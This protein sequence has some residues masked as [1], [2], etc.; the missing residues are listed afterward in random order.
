R[1]GKPPDPDAP[2]GLLA[3]RRR[4]EQGRCHGDLVAALDQPTAQGGGAARHPA[5]GPGGLVER[6][7]VEDLHNSPSMIVPR[8]SRG[9]KPRA[10]TAGATMSAPERPMLLLPTWLPSLGPLVL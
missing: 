1:T 9:L 2:E 6:S 7:D 8:E 5:V 4:V 3:R 10:A